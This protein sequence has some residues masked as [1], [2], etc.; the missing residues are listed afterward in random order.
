VTTCIIKALNYGT[1]AGMI[2]LQENL[3]LFPEM[4]KVN[5][6]MLHN[7]TYGKFSF[8]VNINE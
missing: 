7:K 4:C 6:A 3:N 5:E 1:F 8:S 2:K